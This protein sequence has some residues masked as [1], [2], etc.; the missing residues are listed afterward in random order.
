MTRRDSARRLGC[1]WS[2]DEGQD[3]TEYG[4][5]VA[6]I[7]IVAM[8][9]VTLFGTTIRDVFWATIAANF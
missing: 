3:L 9:G 2:A 6:L 1:L 4:L 7:S 8:T 5:L